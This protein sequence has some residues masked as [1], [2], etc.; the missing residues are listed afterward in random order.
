MEWNF[1][2]I[3]LTIAIIV[4]ILVLVFVG[5]ALSKSKK[6]EKW[7]PIVGNCPDYWMDRSGNGS[8][9]FNYQSLGTCNIPS[10]DDDNVM[11]FNISPY[12]TP[13]GACAK[14]TWAKNCG[15]SW[16]GVTYGAPNPCVRK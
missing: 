8:S 10:S 13:E 6:T 16:D 5:I 3:V 1:Q 4:L 12:N 9:C 15:V 11:N 7:P 2:K 14:Y